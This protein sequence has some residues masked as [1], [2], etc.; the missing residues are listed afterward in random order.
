MSSVFRYYR[1][2]LRTGYERNNFFVTNRRDKVSKLYDD[3]NKLFGS[4]LSACVFRRMVETKGRTHDQ[5]LSTGIAKCS[6]H[7]EET[8]SRYYRV[9]DATEAV[10]RH[11]QIELVDHTALAK[12]YVDGQEVIKLTYL[13]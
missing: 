10:R 7:S 11:E 13:T 1:L 5:A 3:L 6:Q 9:L 2:R 12:S 8:A 4:N